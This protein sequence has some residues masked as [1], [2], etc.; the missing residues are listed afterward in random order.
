M[1]GDLPNNP[2]NDR[3]FSVAVTGTQKNRWDADF[4]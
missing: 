1:G 2:A 3:R 4:D